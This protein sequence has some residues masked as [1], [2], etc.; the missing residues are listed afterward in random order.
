MRPLL[1]FAAASQEKTHGVG[2]GK[3]QPIEL[4]QNANGLIQLGGLR[5]L[6]ESHHGQ[7]EDLGAKRF[8]FAR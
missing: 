4:F 8:Q 5:R 6:G 1:E 3:E 2:A 7:Q